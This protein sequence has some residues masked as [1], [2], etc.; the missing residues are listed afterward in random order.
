MT[1]EPVGERMARVEV[2]LDALTDGF[3]AVKLQL[4]EMRSDRDRR[5]AFEKIGQHVF[6][7]SKIVVTA[8]L[9]AGAATWFTRHGG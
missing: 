5:R 3:A 8:I 6:E 9:G 2:K 1:E 4:E 7:F